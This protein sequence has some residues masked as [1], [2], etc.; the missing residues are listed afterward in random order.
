MK[1]QKILVPVDF[2][3]RSE[4]A[5]K[6]AAQIA[7]KTGAEIILLHLIDLP[8]NEVGM[9]HNGVPTGPAAIILM[10]TARDNFEKLLEKDYLEGLRVE[11]FVD[12]NK[13]FEGISEYAEE[14]N[15]DLIV[16][17]S[18][19]VTGLDSFFVGSNTEKVVRTSRIPVLVIKKP[20]ENFDLK[21][22]IFAS[23]FK[24]ECHRCFAQLIRFIEIYQPDVKLLRV[25]T[26]T[27]FLATHESENIIEDFL[28]KHKDTGF[29]LNF[30][31]VVYDDYSV[32][33]GI[34]NY[35]DK[36]DADLI[37]LATHGRQGLMHFLQD[38]IAEDVVN[39]AERNILTFR[40]EKKK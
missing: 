19:G 15:V 3:Q 1:I 10:E 29:D 34:F 7:R 35:A 17:G 31:K 28:Q 14:K 30:E 20:V 27:N 37:A 18:H 8:S 21:K 36:I 2:S 40:I 32:Q 13:P 25:N 23:S 12:F 22:V 39:K 5:L 16:M 38:S 4:E 11:D 24:E 6:I 26:I 33:Q 9:F